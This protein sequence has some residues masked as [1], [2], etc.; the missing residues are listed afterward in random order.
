MGKQIMEGSCKLVFVLQQHVIAGSNWELGLLILLLACS[1]DTRCKVQIKIQ[2]IQ[3]CI[4]QSDCCRNQNGTRNRIYFMHV[5]LK[6][7][8]YRVYQ[9]SNGELTLATCLGLNWFCSSRNLQLPRHPRFV[10]FV[11]EA[12]PVLSCVVGVILAACS[13]W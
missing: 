4:A 7:L 8:V 3:I 11:L 1:S 5:Y 9:G 2:L 12:F 13:P 10:H 6:L